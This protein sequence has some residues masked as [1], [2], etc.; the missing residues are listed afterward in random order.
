MSKFLIQVSYTRKSWSQLVKEPQ[1][2]LDYMQT[3][4]KNLGGKIESAFLTFGDFDVMGILDLPNDKIAASLSMA[5]MAG[6]GL[7]KIKTTPMLT[8]EDGVNAMINAK[9]ASYKPPT[10]NPML[11]RR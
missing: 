8:W 6:G 3:I 2:R 7:A 9:K 1:N 5:L 11:D 4:V 10:N